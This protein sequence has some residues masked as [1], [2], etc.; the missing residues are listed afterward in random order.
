MRFFFFFCIYHNVVL[1]LVF[2]K[3]KCRFKFPLLFLY[4]PLP[5]CKCPVSIQ[6]GG[7]V[8]LLFDGSVTDRES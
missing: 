6:S 3:F 2:G 5:G 4:L 1:S 7:E 8:E